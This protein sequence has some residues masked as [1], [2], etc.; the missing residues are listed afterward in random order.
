MT[1]EFHDRTLLVTGGAGFLGRTV[2]HDLTQRF[3]GRVVSVH[4][5]PRPPGAAPLPA[6]HTEFHCDLRDGDRWHDLLRTADYVL[7]M[8]A[9][10]DHGASTVEAERQNV[11]PLRAAVSVLRG[12]PR[13]R[14]FVYTS[15]ISAVDQPWFPAR[16]RPIHDDAV[17]CPSTPYGRSKLAAERVLTDSGLPCTILR[18]PFLYGPGFR[19]RSFLDFYRNAATSP[20]LSAVRFTA[21]LSLLYTGDVAGMVL[22]VLAERHAAAADASPYVVSDGRS[23][24]VDEVISMVARLHGRRRP[25]LRVPAALGRTVSAL[26]LGSRA[27]LRPGPVR[28]GRLALLG[29]YW[30]H[31]AATRDY[32]AVDSSRFRSAFPCCTFT[33][34]DVGLAHSFA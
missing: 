30:S 8:A 17:P 18:L 13:F 24:E 25:P 1:V 19:E 34:L 3:P 2:V 4:R 6:P 14:R 27:V 9:L 20:L 33:P 7:W 31:A 26:A 11:A 16:P 22:D 28:R 12:S 15:S 21:N 23:Y 32:F 5:T 29:S 10:R